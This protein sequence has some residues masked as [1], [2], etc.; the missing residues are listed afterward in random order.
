MWPVSS[1]TVTCTEA[2]DASHVSRWMSGKRA[3][4]P[5]P[6]SY[7]TLLLH[8]VSGHKSRR[9]RFSVC[10]AQALRTGARAHARTEL[11]LP[12]GGAGGLDADLHQNVFCCPLLPA[13]VGRDRE[14]ILVLLP[15]VQLL[16]VLDVAFRRENTTVRTQTH[17]RLDL[18]CPLLK[19]NMHAPS[20]LYNRTG[21][22]T[23]V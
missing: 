6:G 23:Y 15:V 4:A 11:T 17:A 10:G 2:T 21:Q 20:A 22:Y 18:R 9:T 8:P 19:Q 16:R 12:R 7:S 13:V 1:S 3:S 5:V 14:L